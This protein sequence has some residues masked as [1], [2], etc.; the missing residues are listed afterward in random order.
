MAAELGIR[1]IA[2]CAPL[3][4]AAS[5][6]AD[7]AAE[8]IA[9]LARLVEEVRAY[10]PHGVPAAAIP[11][12]ETDALGGLEHHGPF[13]AVLVHIGNHAGFHRELLELV[14]ARPAVV[15]LHEVDLRHLAVGAT[16]GVGMPERL[17]DL[18]RR[19]YG[20]SG[21]AAGRRWLEQGSAAALQHRPLFEPVLDASRGVVVHTDWARRR[22]LAAR[23]R[24][25]VRVVP[26][27]MPSL[28][29]P[30]VL[31]DSAHA[32]RSRLGFH[33]DAVL[34]GVFGFVTRCKRV[35]Q[36]LR[37]FQLVHRQLPNAT[38]VV[39]GD[40]SPDPDCEALLASPLGD[41]VVATGRL[42]LEEL[43]ALMAAVDVAVA[44]RHPP[45]GEAS[46]SALRLLGLGRPLITSVAGWCSE[47]PDGAAV[48]V[49]PDRE[50]IA[51]GAAAILALAGD[52]GLRRAVGEAGRRWA[53]ALH[54]RDRSAVAT[55]EALAEL[56]GL[57]PP[58]PAAPPPVP[59]RRS[60]D[61]AVVA[62]VGRALAELGVDDGDDA[63]V[64]SI[65]SRLGD[66]G[67]D[68]D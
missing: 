2:C 66:I 50:E 16:V 52:A 22:I 14:F 5:G 29:A 23:P 12:I 34:V 27:P 43:H 33:R 11:G 59:P 48:H 24:A 37:A 57:D 55:V 61:A 1:R 42:P 4:P 54:D 19:A 56:S 65:S 47:I 67:V 45:A 25:A 32:A 13:D 36:V 8:Q 41:G 62:N 44:L 20:A 63:A 39:A 9:G 18:L 38:L 46:G 6:V 28:P 3:P 40:R 53:L 7:Y 51:N 31:E 26:H 68:L 49:A 21:E 64:E 60:P 30:A 58:H 15:L 10:H 35:P 17:V